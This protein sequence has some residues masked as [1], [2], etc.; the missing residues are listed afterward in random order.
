MT[1]IPE[2]VTGEATVAF[3]TTSY[4]KTIQEEKEEMKAYYENM[5]EHEEDDT[6]SDDPL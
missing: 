1:S 6:N 4:V 3:A 2:D 5:S